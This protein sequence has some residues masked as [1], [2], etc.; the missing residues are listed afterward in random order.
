[1][2]LRFDIRYSPF[3][4]GLGFSN[5]PDNFFHRGSAR[6]SIAEDIP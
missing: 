4:E 5:L 3:F 6:L 1:M 2:I